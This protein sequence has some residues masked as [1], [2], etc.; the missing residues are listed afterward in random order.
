MTAIELLAAFSGDSADRYAPFFTVSDESRIVRVEI[1]AFGNESTT[2][3]YSGG[4]DAWREV[5]NILRIVTADGRE[6]ISGVDSYYQGPFSD[7]HLQAIK[8]VSTDLVALRSLDPVEV[9]R[10]L[11][12]MHP[13]LEDTVRASIDIALWDLAAR[14]S[15]RP[16]YRLL[17]ARRD[18]IEAYASL[19]F[20]ESLP[21]Y[22]AAVNE[23]ARL[24][25]TTFK[26]HVWGEIE[27]DL[28]LVKLT[29]QTFTG[30]PYRFMIDL[31]SV[32]EPGDALALGA[33]MDEGQ[34]ILL[35][36]PLDDS[37]LAEY[38]ELRSKLGV[39]VIPAGYTWYS[40]EYLGQAIEAGAWDAGRF[41][42]TVV[43]GLSPALELLVIANDAGLPI[44]IQSWGH[45]LAQA[46]NL[47]L[48]LA[49][50][51]TPHFEA[52][53][54]KAPFEFGMRNG[55]LLDDGTV[56]VPDVPGLGIVVDWESLG[57][58]DFHVHAELEFP[59]STE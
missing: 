8:S 12:Q 34:F 26:Y 40:A 50:D 17:G 13:D 55:D 45:S 44:E 28:A 15:G 25:F 1:H 27:K 31:E 16:L 2:A 43:G 49:N 19:P 36:A 24:G 23:Y 38:A 56:T 35:E 10:N 41:D 54:P 9:G 57:A 6:G 47:H 46:A 52:P 32:Y 7:E 51:R 3:R 39:Q 21:E 18:L 20:Y 59:G 4:E 11:R 42:V 30:T 33:Q 22:V 5:N 58:A 29:Q 14:K 48:M 37:L 53:M